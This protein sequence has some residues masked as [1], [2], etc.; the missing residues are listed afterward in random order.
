M[1]VARLSLSDYRDHESHTLRGIL[2]SCGL[3]FFG[4]LLGFVSCGAILVPPAD[5]KNVRA[6]VD[7]L[8]EWSVY[9]M[10]MD[11]GRMLRSRALSK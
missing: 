8:Q 5:P 6:V 1:L 10:L 7:E 2:R 4:G 11:W 3:T 9:A